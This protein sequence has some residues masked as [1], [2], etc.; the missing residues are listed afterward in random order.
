MTLHSSNSSAPVNATPSK[1]GFKLRL[2]QYSFLALLFVALSFFA[3]WTA[4]S[5]ETPMKFFYYED[6]ALYNYEYYNAL[7]DAFL[8]G[9]MYFRTPPSAELLSLPDPYDPDDSK[10]LKLHDTVLYKGRY[11]LYHAPVPALA[12]FLPFLMKTG[13]YLPQNFAIVLFSMGGIFFTWLILYEFAKRF[14]PRI[15]GAV[16]LLSITVL[17]F[18]NSIFFTI[19]RPFFYEVA[20]TGGFFFLS[21]GTYLLLTGAFLR[22][23]K[24]LS[25]IWWSSFL[26]G[27]AV[28]CR[29]N[30][31]VA[32][33]LLITWAFIYLTIPNRATTFS[34]YFKTASALGIPFTLCIFAL[35]AYNY[36]RFGSIFEFGVNYLLTVF[37]FHHDGLVNDTHVIPKLL[38]LYFFHPIQIDTVFPFFHLSIPLRNASQN[39]AYEEVGGLIFNLILWCIPLSFLRLRQ[40]LKDKLLFCFILFIPLI[41]FITSL[42][43]CMFGVTMRYQVDYLWLYALA[44]LLAAF[45]L[46]E[47]FQTKITRNIFLAIFSM[48]AIFTICFHVAISFTGYYDVFRVLNPILYY[49]ISEFF[50]TPY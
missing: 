42:S 47:S 11:Y 16:F 32:A 23:K 46:L 12:V 31:G 13:I 35:L 34:P 21:G 19:R 43:A 10:G 44:S 39:V 14:F 20:I 9:Q 38:Y 2:P 27:L 45:F 17:S 33:A 1:T 40:L 22:G 3:V 18:C 8:H 48:T 25:R 5:N 50:G 28:G 26:M 29:P 41:A 7:A 49:K 15:P 4:T 36:A 37:N 30:L 6:P 24:S